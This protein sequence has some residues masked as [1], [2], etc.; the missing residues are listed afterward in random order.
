MQRGCAG[1]HQYR[2]ETHDASGMPRAQPRR[3]GEPRELE[4]NGW[5]RAVAEVYAAVGAGEDVLHYRAGALNPQLE[6]HVYRLWRRA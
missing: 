1:P 2:G 4:L 3:P 5:R 6:G